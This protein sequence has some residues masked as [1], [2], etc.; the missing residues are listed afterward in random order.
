MDSDFKILIS[1][2]CAIQFLK[3]GNVLTPKTNNGTTVGILCK[4]LA[5]DQRKYGFNKNLHKNYHYTYSDV[6]RLLGMSFVTEIETQYYKLRSI[7]TID[8][9]RPIGTIDT[10]RPIGTI[11]AFRPIGTITNTTASTTIDPPY[12]LPAQE[13]F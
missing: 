13:T 9:F 1:D 11:D 12:S 4:L 8:A 5:A 3:K 7:G 10:F 6:I 2:F